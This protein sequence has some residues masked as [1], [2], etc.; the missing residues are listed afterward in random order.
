MRRLASISLR[1]RTVLAGATSAF[2]L[3][4]ASSTYVFTVTRSNLI[5]QI[6]SSALQQSY[7][8]ANEVARALET[9]S[10]QSATMLALAPI[11]NSGWAVLGDVETWSASGVAP[12]GF[13]APPHIIQLTQRKVTAQQVQEVGG[14]K[15]LFTGIPIENNSAQVFSLVIAMSL[16]DIHTSLRTILILLLTSVA[17]ITFGGGGL[18]LWLSRRLMEPL[19]LLSEASVRVSAGDLGARMPEINDGDL[20]VIADNFNTMASNIESRFSREVGFAA[21][22]AHELRNPLSTVK[23]AL[24]LVRVD[25]DVLS[26]SGMMGLDAMSTKIGELEILLADLIEFARHESGQDRASLQEFGV[27]RLIKTLIQRADLPSTILVHKDLQEDCVVLVDPRRFERAF[28]NVLRNAEIHANGVTSIG[29]HVF[30]DLVAIHVDDSGD[31]IPAVERIRVLEPFAR[32]IGSA[33]RPGSGLGL[34]IALQHLR[35]MGGTLTIG[36]S[37]TQGARVTLTIL[38]KFA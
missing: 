25:S 4:G 31:G 9:G 35:L 29:F 37:P 23:T 6:K 11:P 21:Q 34:A 22:V 38:R 2:L 19:H 5:E 32:G 8:V 28:T 1:R 30:E 18:G 33:A 10:S 36:D 17:F 26:P 3:A 16:R 24:D 13:V 15:L 12:E 7:L 14:E 27:T 20:A